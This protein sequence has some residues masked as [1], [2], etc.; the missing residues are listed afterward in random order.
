M[1]IYLEAQNEQSEEKREELLNT[2]LEEFT[3]HSKFY[4]LVLP[5]EETDKLGNLVVDK[6]RTLLLTSDDV[7]GEYYLFV[8]AIIYYHKIVFCY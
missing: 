1:D 4:S 5:S 2:F 3:N 7:N 8:D 6:S